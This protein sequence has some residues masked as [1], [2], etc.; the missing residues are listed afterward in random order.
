M[1]NPK[2][3]SVLS[4]VFV[5]QPHRLAVSPPHRRSH[6]RR[7]V[8][9]LQGAK[10]NEAKTKAGGEERQN[11]FWFSSVSECP[12]TFSKKK[13]ESLTAPPPLTTS[14]SASLHL[15]TERMRPLQLVRGNITDL[16]V[17]FAC[18]D[19]FTFQRSAFK[20]GFDI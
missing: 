12:S 9:E 4:P 10:G 7:R 18:S 16:H 14:H 13:R 8:A 20:V 15:V 1:F 19:I 2:H 5:A 11:A 6:R 17:L 3:K